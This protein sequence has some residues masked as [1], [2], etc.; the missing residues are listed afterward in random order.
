MVKPPTS[1]PGYM[2]DS[3][4]WGNSAFTDDLEHVADL[5][6]PESIRTYGRMRNDT[7]L[8]SVFSSITLPIRSAEWSVDPSG[9]RDEVVQLISDDLG[10]PILGTDVEP[11]PARR[12]GVR[13]DEHLRIACLNFLF[14][15]MP[16]AQKYELDNGKYR[17]VELAERLPSTI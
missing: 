1:L 10:I 12:R 4:I 13:W 9:C 3:V 16:F 5:I 6:W 14:G 8:T 17:L 7:Q 2:S 15:H 11:G